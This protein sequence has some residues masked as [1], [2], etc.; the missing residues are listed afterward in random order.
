MEAPE[1]LRN[2]RIGLGLYVLVFFLKLA[3]YFA[4]N[5]M[6]ILAEAFHSLADILVAGFLLIAAAYSRRE[7]DQ[8][9][10]F[11][12]G[13]AQN[14]AALVAATL[15]ISFTS[16]KL[17]EEAIPRLWRAEIG[18]YQ[19]LPLAI[20][21][22]V[23]SMLLAAVPLVRLLLQPDREPASKALF[24]E[25]VNDELGLAAAL[26][27]TILLT[28]GIPLADPIAAIVVATIIAYNGVR[29]FRENFGYLLGQAPEP[30]VL[31]EIRDL[32]ESVPGVQGVHELRAEYVGPETLHAGLH[33]EVDGGL[34]VREANRIAE[35]VQGRVHQELK[36]G[37]CYVHVD[38]IQ[39][40]EG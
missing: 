19:S 24:L 34:A 35:E 18:D 36:S 4:T 33:I 26:V 2:L 38:A 27:G 8:A 10:M 5:V 32:A 37:Y 39:S 17:Y 9:H 14:V 20:G 25:L 13:R 29:L 16:Y 6:V 12:Y 3:V 40:N 30:A 21:V 1:E 15:F 22:I 28:R 11:G 23:L 31:Q 7:P